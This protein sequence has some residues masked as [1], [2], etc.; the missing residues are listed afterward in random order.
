MQTR[1]WKQSQN[2][3]CS[4]RGGSAI[5]LPVHASYAALDSVS[6][7]GILVEHILKRIASTI[8]S[9]FKE[10]ITGCVSV[11]YRDHIRK[12]NS[13]M[14]SSL[15]SAKSRVLL[16]SPTTAKITR[17]P[18]RQPMSYICPST[19]KAA[20]KTGPFFSSSLFI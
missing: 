7:S 20:S 11:A 19:A 16:D 15:T 18:R 1:F 12:I 9:F 3:E 5:T 10:A 14:L 2:E 8:M 4:H 6:H 13:R 17:D